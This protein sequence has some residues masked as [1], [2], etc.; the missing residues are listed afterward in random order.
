MNHHALVGHSIVEDQFG[1]A[2]PDFLEQAEPTVSVCQTV[3]QPVERK[4]SARHLATTGGQRRRGLGH[5]APTGHSIG[6]AEARPGRCRRDGVAQTTAGF[7]ADREAEAVDIQPGDPQPPEQCV[8]QRE[9]QGDF[10]HVER[11]ADRAAG[12]LY[13][14]EQ[15]EGTL[16]PRLQRDPRGADTDGAA[17]KLR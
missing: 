10:G 11:F 14:A 7:P 5:V 6:P 9:L 16:L 2:N 3:P 12:G 4:L 15:E 17:G 1:P 13:I 8:R